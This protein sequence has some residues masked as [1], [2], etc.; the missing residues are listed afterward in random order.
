[1][2]KIKAIFFD[3]DDTLYSYKGSNSK[4]MAEVKAIEYFCRKHPKFKLCDAFEV[5]TKAKRGIKE[6]IKDL[7]VRGDRGYW[8]IEFL[9]AEH[10]FDKKFAN[11]M[12]NEFWKVSCENIH[13]YYDAKLILQYLKKKGYKLGVI[14]NGFRKWQI[15]RL[16]ATGFRKYFDF[17][18]TT[19]DV[20]Y[21]KPHKEVFEFA[22]KQAKVKPSQA[23]MIGD[24]PIRDIAPANK[25]G[26][27]TVWLRRGKRYYLPIKGKEKANYVVKNFLELCEWF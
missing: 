23:V 26:M 13:G 20:G 15:K 10:N 21:E 4:I 25:L 5:F 22:L 9:R 7:P 16:K 24:N 18:A 6:R 11:E 17:V 8:I 14:T 12:L 2:A 3:L 1:M 19:S 27:T